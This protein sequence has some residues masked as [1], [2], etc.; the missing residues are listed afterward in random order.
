ML[1]RENILCWPERLLKKVIFTFTKTC[2]EKRQADFRNLAKLTTNKTK[3]TK[4]SQSKPPWTET[5]AK[6]LEADFSDSTKPTWIYARK[7]TAAKQKSRE[8]ESLLAEKILTKNLTL[9]STTA[10]NKLT[11]WLYELKTTTPKKTTSTK[12]ETCVSKTYSVLHGV[13]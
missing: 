6:N 9:K 2:A 5:Q 10:K 8:L 1:K 12:N 3:A 11:Y 13:A 7:E 4:Q